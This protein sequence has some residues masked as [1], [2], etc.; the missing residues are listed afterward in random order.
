MT[1]RSM[2]R[3]SIVATL[4]SLALAAPTFAVKPDGA[5]PND[6]FDKMTYAEFTALEISVGAPQE[7]IDAL[8]AALA[9]IDAN[10]DGSVCVMDG[11]DTPGHLGAWLFNVID[12][13][14][15]SL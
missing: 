6:G 12:N 15:H 5:C 3:A 13:T 2:I 7:I 14:S 10:D 8:P 11:P 4:M 1:T 9:T